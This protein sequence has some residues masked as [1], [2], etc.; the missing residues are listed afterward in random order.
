MKP[1]VITLYAAFFLSG[2]SSLVF[3]GV[4]FRQASLAFGNTVWAES[5]VLAGF[6]AGMG[7]GSISMIFLCRRLHRP[8]LFYTI[9]EIITGI[10]GLVLTYLLPYI[11]SLAMLQPSFFSRNLSQH[12]VTFIA[13]FLVL[14]LPSTAMGATLPVMVRVIETQGIESGRAIGLLYGINTLG[15]VL[16]AVVGELLLVKYLGVRNTALCAALISVSAGLLPLAT[17]S[18]KSGA[19][20]AGPVPYGTYQS[21]WT[22]RLCLAPLLAAGFLAGGALLSLEVI[23]VRFIILFFPSYS[24]IFCLML[25]I[26][27][28]G[29]G[30]GAFTASMRLK[31][32][33]DG[34]R[35]LP[36]LS[37][38][39]GIM[40]PLT[41]YIFN[42]S[43]PWISGH[44]LAGI[45]G[46]IFPV[47]F[48]SGVIF[49]FIAKRVQ[50]IAGDGNRS[51]ALLVSWNMFGSMV[52][53][54]VSGFLLI[55][56]LGVEKSFFLIS[57]VYGVI[58]L[59]LYANSGISSIRRPVWIFFI[60]SFMGGL[61]LFPF[62]TM[63]NVS[64]KFVRDQV[65]PDKPDSVL[66]SAKEGVSETIQLVRHQFLGEPFDY[67]LIT[68]NHSMSG[69]GF[70]SRRYMKL[71]A[72]LP[73]AVQPDISKTLLIC[74]GVGSTLKAL[75]DSDSIT[76]IDVVDT[77]RDILDL[78]RIIYP[79]E[80]PLND[81]RVRVV[82]EDGR[83]FL[84]N[85]SEKY[86]LITGEPPPPRY[87]GVE[88]LY[89]REFFQLVYDHLS[90]DGIVTYWLPVKQ[91][92]QEQTASILNAFTSVFGNSSLW[93]GYGYEFILM[94]SRNTIKPVSEE[95]FSTLWKNPR[96]LSA[97]ESI[98]LE[99][100]GQIGTLFLASGE[101]LKRL[102]M[103]TAPMSDDYP[104]KL[105]GNADAMISESDITIWSRILLNP[106]RSFIN[107]ERKGILP[108]AIWQSGSKY[109]DT[110]KFV[111][112]LLHYPIST[113]YFE[114]FHKILTTTDLKMP[115]LFA[116][117]SDANIQQVVNNALKNGNS[118]PGFSYH[119][120]ARYFAER[121]YADSEKEFAKCEQL[122][123]GPERWDISCY[124]MYLLF[125]LG[126]KE[127]AIRLYRRYKTSYGD[128]F[129]SQK[130]VYLLWVEKTFKVKLIGDI[131]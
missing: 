97:L 32:G 7:I 61:I 33:N 82:V 101:A 27:L 39:A 34:V 67:Q 66:V 122:A 75:T 84:K 78:S 19:L 100:P 10:S 37:L 90:P 129:T 16:G 115:V 130:K 70:G 112:Y 103:K 26:L 18:I 126:E 57:M 91:L 69:T 68:N 43:L 74:F 98:G 42:K 111:N 55:P 4:W 21:R 38:C 5:W 65:N 3:E 131:R 36:L 109:M 124:R 121:K 81:S 25:S 76:Q 125:L 86:D 118:N 12:S 89:T 77:S 15:A 71:F 59:C 105:S 13:S 83:F 56:E 94:G 20:A 47:S 120:A 1:T 52:G 72:Y 9:L 22:E 31:A 62:G 63:K 88:S 102:G 29:I 49:A 8:L 117:G 2:T 11:D 53:S 128:E 50:M 17:N 113:D 35:L 110:Q 92:T 79:S 123:S 48:V 24:T 116:L 51:A 119:L 127:K 99:K 104:L 54:L 14:L 41:Y 45:V 6:M 40:I 28:A 60:V 64:L 95:R 96:T 106:E 108:D 80:N 73:L 30:L 46:L 58:A 23:W 87:A 44:Q 107:S 114:A 85:S 93:S